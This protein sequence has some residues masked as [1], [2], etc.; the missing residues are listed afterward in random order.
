MSDKLPTCRKCGNSLGITV[1]DGSKCGGMPGVKYRVCNSCGHAQPI[2]KPP[3]KE[4][5]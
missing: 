3:R 1:E 5:L 4:R 2:T